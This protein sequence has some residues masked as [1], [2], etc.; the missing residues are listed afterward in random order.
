MAE[1]ASGRTPRAPI[2]AANWKMNLLRRDAERY[3]RSLLDGLGDAAVEVVVFPAFPLLL[4]VAAGLAGSRVAWGGQ[5]L[6]PEDAGAH[7]GDV[8]GAQ[9]A[10]AGCAWALAGHSERRRDHGETDER[11]AAKAA[12]AL[13]HGLAPLLCVGE[14]KAERDAGRTFEVLARQLAAALA[15]VAASG[16]PP[17]P[18]ALAYEPVWAIG[19]GDTATP[20]TAQE[21]HRFLRGALAERLGEEAAEAARILYGG[22]V[23]PANAASLFAGA[24]VDG[25]L[26]GGAS[27]DPEE[28]LDIIRGCR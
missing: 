13:R 24:D 10:D 1:R 28:F 4:A 21:A 27:L 16:R 19:T 18:F 23:K 3:C 9:L 26:V 22:S 20:E 6:H 12:A 15:P 14:T 7:T 17:R 11:V 25:F 2:A 8:S 5:D